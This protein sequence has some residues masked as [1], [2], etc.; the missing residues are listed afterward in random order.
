MV[1]SGCL[2]IGL[3]WAYLSSAVEVCRE[4]RGTKGLGSVVVKSVCSDD[5]NWQTI[6][7]INY[8]YY[9]VR[10]L[11]VSTHN[12]IKHQKKGCF[13]RPFRPR[14]IHKLRIGF[15]WYIFFK[16]SVSPVFMDPKICDV[17][18]RSALMDSKNRYYPRLLVNSMSRV[19]SDSSHII[20]K[21]PSP[22]VISKLMISTIGTEMPPPNQ[23]GNML[24]F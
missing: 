13:S 22:L 7:I 6:I 19:L 10:H 15:L 18:T 24:Y 1:M 8:Y 20:K 14:P 9:F 12:M 2:G 23:M 3:L 4:G 17:A 11:I 5:L 21:T 16:K